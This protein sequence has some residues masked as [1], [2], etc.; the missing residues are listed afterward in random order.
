MVKPIP[1]QG[2]PALLIGGRKSTLCIADLHIGY[3][4]ELSESGFNIPDQ[5]GAM[6]DTLIQINEGDNLVIL[7]DLK[8]SI[9]IARAGESIR[10][11]RFL[12]TLADRFSEVTMIAGNHDGAVERLLPENVQFIPSG[13]ACISS[14]GM[15]HG[16]S[17][18]SEDVMNAKTLVWGHLHPC[19]R[20]YDRLGAVVSLKCWL[21]GPVHPETLSE[22]YEAVLTEES[23]II[24][25]FNHLLTGTPVNEKKTSILSP[26][27]RSG[28]VMM[29]DQCGYTLGGVNLGLVSRLPKKRLKGRVR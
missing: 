18:P 16:H 9:P 5:T 23:I 27:M 13:G 7:G 25:S 10:I 8:H 22:R 21:K 17:W 26:L 1:I 29:R 2:F 19:V 6:L 24:P 3:E 4:M 28:F 15:A 14:I 11:S 20:M 12:R